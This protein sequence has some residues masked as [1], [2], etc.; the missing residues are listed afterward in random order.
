MLQLETRVGVI[1]AKLFWGSLMRRMCGHVL[2][3]VC[4]FGTSG[5]KW[6]EANISRCTSPGWSYLCILQALSRSMG[7]QL[8]PW[9]S[10]S[11][12]DG[13][14]AVW[15]RHR[16]LI[17]EIENVCPS[18]SR[19]ACEVCIF[20]VQGW[21]RFI[22][23]ETS[24]GAYVVVTATPQR[25][26]LRLDKCSIPST[27]PLTTPWLVSWMT[28]LFCGTTGHTLERLRTEFWMRVSAL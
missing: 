16:G 15:A 24:E 20:V 28:T 10:F 2:T 6:L 3:D 13:G 25:F 21:V 8:F 11:P 12:F 14:W 22:V 23:T 27:D 18:F 4:I 19:V 5:S 17:I 1:A 7:F 9:F 26:S